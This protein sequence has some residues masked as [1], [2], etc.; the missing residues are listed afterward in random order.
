MKRMEEAKKKRAGSASN[1]AK[2]G[3]AASAD[4]KGKG[5]QVHEKPMIPEKR[6]KAARGAGGKTVALSAKKLA[7]LK[8]AADAND[9]DSDDEP[10]NEMA[11]KK[12][13][14][15]TENIPMNITHENAK[16]NAANLK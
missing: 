2:S 10:L 15:R 5:K 9:D 7:E 16:N 8:R 14:K 1:K 3:L 13:R 11:E 6:Q 4:G 12:K